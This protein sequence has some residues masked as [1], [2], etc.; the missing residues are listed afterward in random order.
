MSAKWINI[1]DPKLMKWIHHGP[2][3]FTFINFNPMDKWL[4]PP[5]REGLNYLS[6]PKRQRLQTHLGFV[7]LTI[8]EWI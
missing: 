6:I 2:Y 4:H 5:K 3:L 7:E 1:K 8:L